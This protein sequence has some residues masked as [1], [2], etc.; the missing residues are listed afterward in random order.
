MT[1]IFPARKAPQNLPRPVHWAT[2]AVCKN[3]DVHPETWFPVP[4]D[5]L[6]V[7]YAK[8]LCRSCPVQMRCRTDALNRGEEHGV[9]GGLDENELRAVRAVRRAAADKEAAQ[10]KQ[11]A[12]EQKDA[13]ELAKTG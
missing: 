5:P 1:S 6:G 7:E 3:P 12:Q 13:S 8:A 4:T 2:A 11:A 10:E 9:W